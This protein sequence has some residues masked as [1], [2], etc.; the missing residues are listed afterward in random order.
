MGRSVFAVVS[1]RFYGTTLH[2]F[3]ANGF[4]LWCRRLLID[5]GISVVVAAREI[6]RCGFPAQIAIDALVI[7]VD[8]S[9]NIFGVFVLNLCHIFVSFLAL[10]P[11]SSQAVG[12]HPSDLRKRL[13]AKVIRGA[14]GFSKEF[15]KFYLAKRITDTTGL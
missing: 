11:L 2:C 4:F 12:G 5:V 1:D 15:H 14:L 13:L 6:V 3:L 7:D 10:G 9:F 8:F